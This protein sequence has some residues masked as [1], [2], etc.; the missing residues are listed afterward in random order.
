[1]LS[2]LQ[3]TRI[4]PFAGNNR[5]TR[6]SARTPDSSSSNDL[7][8]R[9]QPPVS[10][11]LVKTTKTRT[12][13]RAE[14]EGGVSDNQPPVSKSLPVGG[15]LSAFSQ[16]W[17]LVTSH[18]WMLQTV[19]SGYQLRVHQPPPKHSRV[20]STETRT[21]ARHYCKESVSSFSRK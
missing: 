20:S 2:R 19:S 14:G 16:R 13:T 21:S 15:R 7:P 17:G 3:P 18:K 8:N 5:R 10:R 6:T 1:M 11:N 4:S 12:A 9:S